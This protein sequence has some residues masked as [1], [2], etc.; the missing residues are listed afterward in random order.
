MPSFILKHVAQVWNNYYDQGKMVLVESGPTMT[1]VR[2]EK[3]HLPD[4]AL[5]IRV[6]GWMVRAVELSGGRNVRMEHPACANRKDPVCEW[7]VR[8]D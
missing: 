7:K 1:Q 5:C 8:W 3:A 2:L 4:A 6:S